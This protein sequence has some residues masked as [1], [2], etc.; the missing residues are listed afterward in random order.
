M[1]PLLV[2]AFQLQTIDETLVNYIDQEPIRKAFDELYL[3]ISVPAATETVDRIEGMKTE[4]K[5]TVQVIQAWVKQNVA[6]KITAVTET[7]K[8]MVR[9]IILEELDAGATDLKTVIKNIRTRWI[10]VSRRRAKVIARTEVIPAYNVG[11]LA[12][13]AQTGVALRKIWISTNDSRT[14]DAHAFADG[15]K[16]GMDE[17]FSVNGERLSFPGDPRGS[18]ENVIN[19]RCAL[20]YEAIDPGI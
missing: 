12:G 3:T 2:R 11:S 15:Q 17:D 14:R 18:A 4:R 19:C 13:A 20:G 7:T 6:H 5:F 8:K 1:N 9:D 10:G 16:R